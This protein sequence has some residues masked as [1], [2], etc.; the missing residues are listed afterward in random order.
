MT[1]EKKNNELIRIEDY[2]GE[3]SIYAGKNALRN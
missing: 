3:K 2:L 1:E